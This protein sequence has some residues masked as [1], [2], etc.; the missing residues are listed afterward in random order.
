MDTK[1]THLLVELW[2]CDEETLDD[3]NHISVI[4]QEAAD[5][6]RVTVLDF[7]MHHFRPQGVSGVV[8]IAESHI[9]IHTWPERGYAAADIFTC[10]SRCDPRAAASKMRVLL[11]A[12]RTSITEIQRGLEGGGARVIGSGMVGA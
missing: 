1:S 4:L 9:T 8:V 5:A 12:T 10:G 2:G 11:G 6:A 3:V 7:K